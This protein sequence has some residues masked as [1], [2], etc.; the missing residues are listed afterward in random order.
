[1]DGDVSVPTHTVEVTVTMT[2]TL[3]HKP[4]HLNRAETE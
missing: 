2:M 4:T 3:S 1:M